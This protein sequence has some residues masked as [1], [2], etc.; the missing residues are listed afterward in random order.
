MDV[1]SLQKALGTTSEPVAKVKIVQ[2]KPVVTVKPKV[3]RL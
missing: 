3:K 2:G 1:K